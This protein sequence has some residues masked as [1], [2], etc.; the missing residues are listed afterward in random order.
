MT[1][2][3]E[4]LSRDDSYRTFILNLAHCPI[5][6]RTRGLAPNSYVRW[7]SVETAYNTETSI[8]QAMIPHG[9]GIDIRH[10]Y[11]QTD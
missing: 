8:A 5:V 11:A 2:K 1:Q 6:Y 7:N 9:P 3:V 4:P 10:V